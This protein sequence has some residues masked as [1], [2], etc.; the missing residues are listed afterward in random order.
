MAD[1]LSLQ[2]RETSFATTC[3]PAWCRCT[4]PCRLRTICSRALGGR[5]SELRPMPKNPA[6]LEATSGEVWRKWRFGRQG[7]KPRSQTLA[8]GF[9]NATREKSCFSRYL[10][11]SICS[12][13]KVFD[14]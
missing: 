7:L 5:L 8:Q 14:G 2:E 4:L 1:S 9:C 6:R 10:Q 12:T 3:G 13:K 11:I